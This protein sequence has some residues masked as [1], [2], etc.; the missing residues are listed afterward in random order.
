MAQEQEKTMTDQEKVK[1]ILVAI[2]KNLAYFGPKDEP[3]HRHTQF[4]GQIGPDVTFTGAISDP[5]YPVNHGEIYLQNEN[6]ELAEI[7]TEQGFLQH[8]YP[9]F[10]DTWGNVHAG[11][12]VLAK[13]TKVKIIA[14]APAAVMESATTELTENLQVVHDRDETAAAAIDR[15]YEVITLSQAKAQITHKLR[16]LNLPNLKLREATERL[17]S[18]LYGENEQTQTPDS[19]REK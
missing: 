16:E 15:L 9:P 12:E 19:G 3:E 13:E 7:R 14:D 2:Q 6:K 4:R 5:F 8:P 10:C 1:S 18:V 11:R 17:I